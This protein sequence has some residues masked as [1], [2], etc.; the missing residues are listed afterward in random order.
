MRPLAPLLLLLA[1]VLAPRAAA[2]DLLVASRFTDEVLRYDGTTGAFVGVFA[3]GGGLD[4]PVGLTF[5]PDGNLYVA[6]GNNNKVLRYD[7]TTG[8][9][10]GQFNAASGLQGPRQLNFGPDGDLYVASGSNARIL[11]FDGT[12]GASL[13]A[14][15][16][17]GGLNG[18]TGFTFGP[19][20]RLY[21]G[22]VLTD[23]VL[24]YDGATGA[25]LDVFASTG[26]DGPHDLSFGPD[27][28]L[29]VSNAFSHDV[30]RFDGSTGRLRG[31]FVSD[32]ALVNPLGLI[33]TASAD[34]LVANQGGD[35]VRRYDG[36]TGALIDVFVAPGSGGLDAPLFLTRMP[37]RGG[38]RV[39]ARVPGLAGGANDLGI[40]G[41]RPGSRVFLA[42]A[43]APGSRAVPG[44]PGLALDLDHPRVLGTPIAD[45]SGTAWLRRPIPANLAGRPIR[46][47][48]W[49]AGTCTA[50]P[51]LVHAFP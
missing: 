43:L 46:L 3:S 7:G 44:C 20:G 14:F 11:R 30:L 32:P 41:A 35:E 13:G 10:L 1:P 22:S 19:D 25:F 49:D 17:G 12:S 50:S 28:D 40:T 9:F 47:Q 4:N 15:A 33:W 24:R 36:R 8:A 23:Q 48:A 39:L 51:V 5:G 21:V 16:F 38:P 26:L 37:V 2:Q 45:E 42:A 31:A 29:Y 18:P 27:G 34:L 6:S